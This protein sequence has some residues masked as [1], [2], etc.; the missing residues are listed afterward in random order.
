MHLYQLPS[1]P[2][3]TSPYHYQA[4]WE[5]TPNKLSEPSARG[6]LWREANLDT[7]SYGLGRTEQGCMSS[8]PHSEHFNNVGCL[9]LYG[10][11]RDRV[12]FSCGFTLHIYELINYSKFPVLEVL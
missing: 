2:L 5:H 4:F 7:T 3:I 6:L 10:I 1:H 8:S 12:E 9:L 11:L